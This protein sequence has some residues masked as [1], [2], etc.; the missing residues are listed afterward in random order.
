MDEYQNA[1]DPHSGLNTMPRHSDLTTLPSFNILKQ[2]LADGA[3]DGGEV[4]CFG[5]YA[6][7]WNTRENT[8]AIADSGGWWVMP[9][10][11]LFDI[12]AATPKL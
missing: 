5:N 1:V 7:S 11:I 2:V 6:V 4:A 9:V 8:V 10:Q 12:T 3:F